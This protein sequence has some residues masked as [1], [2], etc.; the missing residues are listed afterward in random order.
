M[1]FKSIFSKQLVAYLVSILAAFVVLAVGLSYMLQDFFVSQAADTLVRQGQR[2][3]ESYA[4]MEGLSWQAGHRFGMLWNQAWAQL[5]NDMRTLET[6]GAS[7]FVVAYF[8]GYLEGVIS[9]GDIRQILLDE[10]MLRVF[11]GEIVILP[12]AA[13]E[14]FDIPMLAVGYPIIVSNELWGAIFMNSPMDDIAAASAAAM[15]LVWLSL[16][17]ALVVSLVL[18]FVTSRNMSRRITT[19]GRAAK[20]I[21]KGGTGKR[22]EDTAKDEIGQLAQ[23]FNHMAQSLDDTE[24]MRR[25]F[26]ANISHDLRSP[27]TSM[28]G[29]LSAMLDGTVDEADREKYL[30]IVL[31]ETRRLSTLANDILVLTKIQDVDSSEMQITEFDINEL[32]R[33]SVIL[34][35]PQITT[36]GLSISVDFS[37]ERAI[38]NADKEKISRIVYNLIE[39]AVKFTNTG[40]IRLSTQQKNS[41][42]QV[43]IADTGI[44][45]DEAVQNKIFDRFYKADVSRGQHS[46]SGLGLS[47]VK[48]ML[49]AH[50]EQIGVESTPGKGSVFSFTLPQA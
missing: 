23:S 6:L 45:M 46:G 28:Q 5:E 18:V 32:L 3:A 44:G 40:E 4:H 16:L 24:N 41:K 42:I 47:I 26:I 17:L 8:D 35:E 43:E 15:Q 11:D 1:M 21:A 10:E 36:G 22:I 29:F 19:V 33:Q 34:F 27:L 13:G 37:H 49:A 20:E 9:T 48:D 39:N 2:V 25:E 50:G 7:A 31:T 30:E 14:L 12:V 38:V